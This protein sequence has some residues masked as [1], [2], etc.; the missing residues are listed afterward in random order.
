[1]PSWIGF[2][3]GIAAGAV[4]IVAGAV[5]HPASAR[6]IAWGVWGVVSCV[7]AWIAG[8][9]AQP[10]FGTAFGRPTFGARVSAV[11]LWAWLIVLGL[12]IAATVIGFVV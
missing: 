4:L 5:L 1:M 7:L 8:A 10:A 2:I 3:C 9:T 11:P 12:F 6:L